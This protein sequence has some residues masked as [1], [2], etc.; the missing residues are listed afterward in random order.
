MDIQL[1]DFENAALTVCVGLIANV[2]NTYDLNFILPVSLVDENMKRAHNRDG[3]LTTK[4]WWKMP[5]GPDAQ[6]LKEH[7]VNLKES[8]FVKSTEAEAEVEILTEEER[9]TREQAQYQELFIW[10]ILNGDES[11][12]FTKGLFP[13]C[14]Q[15]MA[16]KRW[17]EAKIAE[18][19][20]C[21]NFLSDR[22]T[23][24]LP[25]GATFLRDFV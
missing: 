17:P 12:G 1:T 16:L 14:Q 11:I 24:K 22:A 15:Y 9:K 13:L 4:F 7:H 10:Q 20:E 5:I 3:L 18:I 8:S 6:T 2:V 19:T 25:T 23:G 21:L